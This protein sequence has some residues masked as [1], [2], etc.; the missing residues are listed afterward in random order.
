MAYIWL[1]YN[2]EQYAFVRVAVPF[3]DTSYDQAKK[4]AVDFIKA[5]YPNFIQ[6]IKQ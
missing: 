4:Q 6:Y 3:G 2:D 5:F 1:V